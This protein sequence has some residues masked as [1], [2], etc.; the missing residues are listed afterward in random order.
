MNPNTQKSDAAPDA[1]TQAAAHPPKFDTLKSMKALRAASFGENQAEAIVGVVD[2]AQ[3]HLATKYDLE[4]AVG[5][6]HTDMGKM[7]LGL[8]ADMEK[9]GLGLRADM[10]K[11]RADIQA[12]FKRLYWYIPIVMG[13]VVGILKIT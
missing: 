2:D 11:M 3:R 6:L 4:R 13:V 1:R 10:E 12:E 9:M 5:G 8:R 7:E